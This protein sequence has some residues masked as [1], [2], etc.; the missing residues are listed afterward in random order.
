MTSQ[1]I[2]E[3]QT[4]IGTIYCVVQLSTYEKTLP[5]IVKEIKAVIK[6]WTK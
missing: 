3:I 1:K 2:K 4:A 6:A 5:E